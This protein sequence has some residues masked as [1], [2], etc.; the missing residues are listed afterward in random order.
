M[1]DH[2]L[3]GVDPD[4]GKASLTFDYKKGTPDTAGIYL[5][6]AERLGD[7]WSIKAVGKVE[8]PDPHPEGQVVLQGSW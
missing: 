6:L 7:H 1:I 5:T 3:D 4:H 2:A 8:W